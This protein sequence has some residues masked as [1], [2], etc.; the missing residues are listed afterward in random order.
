[1]YIYISEGFFEVAIECWL[2]LVGFEPATTEYRSDSL[3]NRA[4][5]P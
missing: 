5:R 2:A 1:M 3:T 4:I